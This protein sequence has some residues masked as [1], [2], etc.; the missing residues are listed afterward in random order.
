[1]R[2]SDY[3]IAILTVLLACMAIIACNNGNSSSGDQASV[4]VNS[5]EGLAKL[6]K[7]AEGKLYKNDG[8]SFDRKQATNV[9]DAY[10]NYAK[11]FPQDAESP[12]YLFKAAEIYRSMRNYKKATEI[13]QNIH[14]NYSNFDKAPHSLFL[15][16][17]I[18]END[19]K[20]LNKAKSVYEQFIA[21]YPKHELSDDV[22]FSL[23]NLGKPAEEII[24]GFEGNK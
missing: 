8:G 6:I 2:F 1:M 18:Y 22:Q 3:F 4:D 15:L 16:G 20:D 21:E 12:Q 17:F 19:L 13:Y 5:K 9:V 11:K 14:D 24:K 23:N 10:N 7:E